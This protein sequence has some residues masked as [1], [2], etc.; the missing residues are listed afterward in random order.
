MT[1]DFGVR[2]RTAREAAGLSQAQLALGIVSASH[3][4]LL[5][6]GKRRP[7]LESVCALAHRLGVA[8]DD[9]CDEVDALV[10]E[11]TADALALCHDMVDDG[12]YECAVRLATKVLT[13]PGDAGRRASALYLRSKAR[14]ALG[15][16]VCAL[17]DLHKAQSIT[18]R[19]E[20]PDLRVGIE[21]QLAHVR[22]RRELLAA[23]Q[24]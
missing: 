7:S 15:H 4:S 18:W 19:H 2:L 13:S 20:L 21:A 3:L 11:R 9:I 1:E 10:R 23:G 24:A 22:H 17:R 5:E 16:P 14:M 8:A 12:Q 6:T